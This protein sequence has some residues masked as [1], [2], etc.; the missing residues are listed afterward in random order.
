MVQA[1]IK[2]DNNTNRVLN[3]IKAKYDF[4]DK[5]KAIEYVVSRYIE[6]ENEPELRP[7]FIK[8]MKNIEKE[9]SIKIDNFVKRYELE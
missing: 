1:L 3:M 5:S 8:K 2:L 9:K 4:K 6:E 7:E